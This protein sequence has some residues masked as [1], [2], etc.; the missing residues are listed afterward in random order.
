M[1]IRDS[2]GISNV[3]QRIKLIYGAAYGVSI[4]SIRGA[5]TEIRVQLP[6]RD[7]EEMKRYV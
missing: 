4:R 7:V 2:I 6:A 3:N 5:G 1:C